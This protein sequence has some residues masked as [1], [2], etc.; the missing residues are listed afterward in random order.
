[1]LWIILLLVD[2]AVRNPVSDEE[3]SR[4]SRSVSEKRANLEA[5]KARAASS[6]TIKRANAALVEEEN[7]LEVLIA[8]DLY[9]PCCAPSVISSFSN[10]RV[11]LYP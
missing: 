6:K 8:S 5:L 1:M 11:V 4:V 10:I 7:I 3:F 2:V 9:W